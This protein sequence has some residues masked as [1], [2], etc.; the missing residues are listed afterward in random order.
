MP[1]KIAG[2]LKSAH[3]DIILDKQKFISRLTIVDKMGK[4][5][6]LRPNEEQLKIID[7]LDGPDDVLIF[8]GRQ[9]GS[10]TICCAYIFWKV[11]T[12]TEPMTF[13]TMSHKTSSSRHLL[14]IIKRFHDS[15]PLALQREVAVDNGLEFRFA[16]T[17]AGVIAVS[18]EG[19]GGLRSFSCNFCHI[20]EFAFADKPDE[21]KATAVAALNGG[22]LV[23]E[24]TANRWGDGLQK[25][26]SRAE[27]GEAVWTRLFFPWWQH[28]EYRKPVPEGT[29]WRNEELNCKERFNL[30]WEQLQWRRDNIGKLGFE[31]FRREYP[32]S[33][34]EAYTTAGT[35]YFREED[36]SDVEVLAVDNA[37]WT[38]Y[39]EPDEADAYAIGVDVSGGVGKDY[40]IITVMSKMTSSPVAVWRSNVTEPVRLAEQIIDIGTDY[41]KALVLVESN[42]FGNVVLNQLRHDGYANLW[43]QD[44]KDWQTTLKS[45]TAMFEKLKRD[46]QTGRIRHID[47][48]THDEL[49]SITVSERGHIELG[50]EDGAH[51]DSAVALALANICLDKVKLSERHILPDWIR[52]RKVDKV[53]QEW[54]ARISQSR[55]YE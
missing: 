29:V 40:S 48:L 53:V 25:E 15:L 10:T 5:Q 11:Y 54:G 37:H 27:R 35:M 22:K 21:L 30:D 36:F 18:T 43:K 46:L 52:K 4:R 1:A 50:R 49:R 33:T 3:R 41:N 19:K 26:W 42:N 7:A 32:A 23:I 34:D 17:G 51:S 28:A 45:K 8:K 14:G 13:A 20:S 38:V 12:S 16:D 9:I 24:T 55:R 44:G 2:L 6:K 47:K 31:K 39:D